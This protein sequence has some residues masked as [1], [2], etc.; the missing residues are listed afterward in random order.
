MSTH[1]PREI[2]ISLIPRGGFL[3]KNVIIIFMNPE[4]P[5]KKYLLSALY[6]APPNRA[7]RGRMGTVTIVCLL[8]YQAPPNRAVRDR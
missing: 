2:A 1:P 5:Y 7:V 8:L 4:K 3:Y 6:Q